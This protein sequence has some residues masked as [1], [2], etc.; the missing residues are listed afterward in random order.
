[1]SILSEKIKSQF[2]SN[3]EIATLV[4]K[5]FHQ[6]VKNKKNNIQRCYF[7]N[8]PN[9]VATCV[10]DFILHESIQEILNFY[11]NT[12]IKKKYRT[13]LEHKTS[14]YRNISAF[15]LSNIT[16]YFKLKANTNDVVVLKE[17]IQNLFEIE[18]HSLKSNIDFN[19]EYCRKVFYGFLATKIYES[20]L[21]EVG[22]NEL[23]TK[24]VIKHIINHN[25]FEF[26]IEEYNN[27]TYTEY[28]NKTQNYQSDIFGNYT[29]DNII[30]ATSNILESIFKAYDVNISITQTKSVDELLSIIEAKSNTQIEL[31]DENLLLKYFLDS[32]SSFL[33]F[34]HNKIL[35]FSLITDSITQVFEHLSVFLQKYNP[36][37]NA[38]GIFNSDKIKETLNVIFM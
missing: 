19:Y 34:I 22:I 16:S 14:D 4:K 30:I 28:M 29:V 23:D 20:S 32:D 1:M 2:K 36:S 33:S 8:T 27:D 12:N 3:E 13:L 9:N 6:A 21:T 26:F 7:I 35:N 15:L 38:S 24:G 10:D 11:S 5:T 37:I 18:K 17:E 25:M 31:N